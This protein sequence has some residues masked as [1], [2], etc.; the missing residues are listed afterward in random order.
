MMTPEQIAAALTAELGQEAV[1]EIVTSVKSPYIVVALPAFRRAMELLRRHPQLSFDYLQLVTAVDWVSHFDVVYH[2]WSMDHAHKI[3]VKVT[4]SREEPHVPSVADLWPAA[5]WH[6]R[7]QYDLLG[8]V[9][10]GHPDLRR[11]LCPE[12]WEGHPLRKDYIQPLEYHGISNVRRIGD[13]WY[14]K[15]DE[16]AKAIIQKPP[17]AKSSATPSSGSAPGKSVP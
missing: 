11:I 5:D 16:D 2:L 7:E 12:D 13:D 6:E 4:V 10:D 8:V 17:P 1:L 3:A 15:P 14:P 9:F